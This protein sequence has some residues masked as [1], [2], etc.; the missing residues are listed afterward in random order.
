NTTDPPVTIT[1]SSMTDY[2]SVDEPSVCSIPLPPLEKLD[3]AEPVFGPKTIQSIL[4]SKS[5]FKYEALKGVIINEPSSAP[6]TGNKS[7]SA[8]KVNSAPAGKLKNVKDEDDPPLAICERTDHRTCD[9]VE[10]MST[11]NITQHLKGQVGSSSRSRTPRPSKHFFS[12]CTHYGFSDHLSDDCVNYSIYDICGSY[13]HDTYGH[14]RIISLRR[15]IKPRNPH[16]V[17]KSYE[18]YGSIVHTI[19]GHNDMEWFRRGEALQAKKAE[20][21]KTNKTKT[22]NANRSKTPT[23]R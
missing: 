21:L 8:L 16:H 4:K 12:P 3:G 2:D 15:G 18:T 22:S 5:T 19:T 17:M 13:D 14:N 23:K 9:H 6:A 10:H 20:A 1:D 7:A 11:I